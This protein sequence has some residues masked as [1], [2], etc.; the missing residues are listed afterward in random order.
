MSE[1]EIHTFNYRHDGE[2][3]VSRDFVYKSDYDLLEQQYE[4]ANMEARD[5]CDEIIELNVEVEK[6]EAK[7]KIARELPREVKIE[8]AY[9][10]TVLVR[11]NDETI[12]LN[13]GETYHNNLKLT[14]EEK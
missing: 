9:N 10:D 1:V 8:V 6:L 3:L 11:I 7:L 14:I 2:R 12:V 5:Y 13:K 4:A